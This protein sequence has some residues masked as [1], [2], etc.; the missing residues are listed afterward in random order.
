MVV[1][2]AGAGVIVPCPGC[3]Q[4][5]TVPSA[6][7]TPLHASAARPTSASAFI[8]DVYEP[9]PLY[10]D[11]FKDEYANNTAAFFEAL[12]VASGVDENANRETV[13]VI[14]SLEN[15]IEQ[16]TSSSSNWKL[17]R[18]LTVLLLTSAVVVIGLFVAHLVSPESV[19]LNLG[20]SWLLTGIATLISTGFF[21][22]TKL[23]PRIR[24]LGERLA[25]QKEELASKMR[26]A[27]AQLSEI[28]RLY[29][30]GMFAKLIQQTVPRLILDPFFSL[31]RLYELR[32]SFGWDDNFSADKSVVF[33]QTGEINGNPF[34]LAET[35]DFEWGQKTYYGSLTI[36]WQELVT[37]TDRDGNEQE[38]WV[39]RIETLNATVTK[40]APNYTRKKFLIYGNEA[41]PDLVF[42]RSPSSLSGSDGGFFDKLRLKSTI[43]KL[44]KLSRNL[45]D[46][47]EF[48]IMS[49][50][51]FDALFYSI[52]RNHEI[53]YRVLFT[54]LAQQQMVML[55]KDKTV[56][57]GDDFHFIKS[58]MINFVHPAHLSGLDITA[59]PDLFKNYDL[60]DARRFFNS[61]S[62]D[63]F[64]HLYF[65]LAPL[66]TIPLYQQHRSH[67]DIYK[68]VYGKTA[69]FWEHEAIANF[70][71]QDAFRHPESITENILKTG[72]NYAGNIDVTSHGFRSEERVEY[73]LMHG[74][75]GNL[76]NVPVHWTE[77]LPVQQ[78]TQLA[79]R[80]T[81]GL[82][83]Q[84]FE[85]QVQ[86]N[87]D[88][89]SFFRDTNADA[90]RVIFRRSIASV[91]K[92]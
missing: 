61:Y 35:L 26:E 13:A 64:K 22:K 65:A 17:L 42:S 38:H 84:D 15:A 21:L 71:G 1:D 52:D 44:E 83:L 73:V 46:G 87:A 56:G 76:H 70:H 2:E 18:I 47:S 48:T 43:K 23:N 88:W 63:Y 6:Q 8:D 69:S 60:V 79:I 11:N 41:A 45:D 19:A 3:N 30:W 86:T 54:P 72:T 10:R 74:G 7:P 31:A 14:R 82:T 20:L 62:N 37:Y 55:L 9:L 27:W 33:A 5:L 68:S 81:D 78:T 85:Q 92:N 12:V 51:E 77:Y 66:L 4:E 90:T 39:T 32:E 67:A 53:Q 28:N 49:N 25:V 58:R 59:A 50:R 16:N 40:P 29:D 89:Q 80:E 75:D 34:V 57:F 91:L 36:S 24:A